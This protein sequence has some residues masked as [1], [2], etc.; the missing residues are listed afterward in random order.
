MFQHVLVSLDGSTGSECALPYA[1]NVAATYGAR[2]TAIG[3]PIPMEWEEVDPY[4]DARVAPLREEGIVRVDTATALGE[5][6][7]AIV[8]YA[9][10]S[11]V[12]LI[13]MGTQG[14]GAQARYRLGSIAQ[15]VLERAPCPVLM[16][17]IPE[18][19]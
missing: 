18:G 3:V 17:R 16:V 12:D 15:Q 13:V 19:S 5:P 11:N 6:G 9:Q 7:P 2:L 8:A 14:R 4:L 10:S 1:I